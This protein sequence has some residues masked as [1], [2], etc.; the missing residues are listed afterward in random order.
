MIKNL[1]FDLGNVL[2]EFKPLKYLMDLGIPEA[3]KISKIIFKDRRWNEFDRG[4]IKLEKYITDLKDENPQYSLYFD[5][6]FNENWLYKLFKVKESAVSFLKEAS[7]NY[8][9]YILSNISEQVL[10]YV[11]TLDF[12]K[13]VTAGTYSYMIKSCKPEEKIYNAFVKENNLIPQ[14][15]LFLDDIPANIE[16]AKKIG[17][18]GIVFNDNIDEV[19]HY[20]EKQK[21]RA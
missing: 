10:N 1:V 7:K 21:Y 9:I 3:E 17:I 13:Y 15:C 2:V 11:K 8:N 6:I 14:E 20:L 16:G 19:I 4:T 18:N 12:F 5:M